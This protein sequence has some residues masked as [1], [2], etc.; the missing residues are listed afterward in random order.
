MTPRPITKP[1]PIPT[2]RQILGWTTA[3]AALSI[4]LQLVIGG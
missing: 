1:I 2:S 4:I 3:M